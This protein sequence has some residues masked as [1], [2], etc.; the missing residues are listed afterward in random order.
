MKT[1]REKVD[2]IKDI[3]RCPYAWP[4]GYEK[5]MLADDGG[6]ICHQCVARE[7]RIILD[8]TRKGYKD[9]WQCAGVFLAD[10][11]DDGVICD[12]CYRTITEEATGEL[13]W[14]L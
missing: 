12:H 11:A 6:A 1:T 13:T 2:A 5:V 7:Y 8:S 14:N 9:G 3:I 10:D 4:G